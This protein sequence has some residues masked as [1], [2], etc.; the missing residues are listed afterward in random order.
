MATRLNQTDRADLDRFIEGV[1]DEI[2]CDR[3]DEPVSIGDLIN[4]FAFTHYQALEVTPS[5][6]RASVKR[7]LREYPAVAFKLRK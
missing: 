1:T 2:V 5:Q 3:R 6:I 4:E 7:V